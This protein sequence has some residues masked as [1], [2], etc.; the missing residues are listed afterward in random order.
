[1]NLI[2]SSLP[3]T[4][5]TS[6][7]YLQRRRPGVHP[8][9]RSRGDSN[10]PICIHMPSLPARSGAPALYRLELYV[11]RVYT[12]YVCI[13]KPSL[14]AVRVIPVFFLATNIYTILQSAIY[15]EL[16]HVI[17]K[18]GPATK[19]TPVRPFFPSLV[20]S[21]QFNWMGGDEATRDG[22]SACG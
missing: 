8:H 22:R 16:S 1:M 17:G 21:N 7:S 6:P 15:I 4:L 9:L 2:R 20:R 13:Y 11:P 14:S 12:F 5:P 3:S 10:S 18:G 19:I